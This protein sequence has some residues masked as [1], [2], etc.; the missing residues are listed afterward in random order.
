MSF[1][2]AAASAKAGSFPGFYNGRV[3]ESKSSKEHLE[4]SFSPHECG[5]AL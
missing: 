1:G 5:C 3:E 2:L 4:K